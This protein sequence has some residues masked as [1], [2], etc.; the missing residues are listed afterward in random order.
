MCSTTQK[1]YSPASM[2]SCIFS[3][4][5][6][7][8]YERAQQVSDR[9][10]LSWWCTSLT[11]T[12]SNSLMTSMEGGGFLLRHKLESV[13]VTFLINAGCRV[14]IQRNVYN[15]K[16]PLWHSNSI[17]AIKQHLSIMRSNKKTANIRL[18]RTQSDF[19]QL[20]SRV[21]PRA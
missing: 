18:C 17:T 1:Y 8:M 3:F 7:V 11:S 21:P 9:T 10:S 12:G 15:F 19:C 6:S 2:T 16:I 20:C 14:K 5:P 4:G 13:H